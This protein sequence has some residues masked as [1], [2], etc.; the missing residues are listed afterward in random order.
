MTHGEASRRRGAWFWDRS[1]A[2]KFSTALFVMGGAFALVG[3]SAAVAL[4]QVAD[5]LQ[6]MSRLNVELQRSFADL[7]VNQARSHVVLQ[8]AVNADETTRA[9]L[10]TSSGWID[11]EVEE[12]A[13]VVAT[14]PAAD[15]P[16]WQDFLARWEAWTSYRD[17][18]LLPLVEA[19]DVT[20]FAAAVSSDVS[21]DPDWAGRALALASAQTD[22]DV[23]AIQEAGQA[24]AERS[25]VVLVVG[26]V[27]ATVCGV[28]LAVAIV[29]RI[30]RSVR[31]VGT[32]LE[33]MAEGDLTQDA[34]VAENDEIGR[35]A[36]A[37]D[38]ARQA[39]RETLSGVVE[40]AQTVAAASEELSAA[41]HQVASGSEETSAQ[42]GV[43]ASAAEQ[44][45]QNVQT[46]AAGAEE[47]G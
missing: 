9:Q 28:L 12:H 45:S 18:T 17:A 37:L 21:A 44:V 41:S 24:A 30:S 20:G 40:S 23:V 35:M 33:A 25:I 38:R 32:T 3:G 22:A 36:A 2:A 11:D 10:L 31:Q 34:P 39:L 8:R 6:E 26:F 46:V 1:L 47:M 42:A 14:F 29:R 5:D 4:S 13:A 43:V 16:Q 19:G 27:V 7:S 15:T